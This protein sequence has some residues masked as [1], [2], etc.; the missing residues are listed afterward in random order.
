[1][2]ICQH[3]LAGWQSSRSANIPTAASLDLRHAASGLQAQM[4]TVS[5]L[6]LF[7]SKRVN[8]F[9]YACMIGHG[10]V[11]KRC[12]FAVAELVTNPRV[13]AVSPQVT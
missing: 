1:M 12:I 9:E 13:Q 6:P 4:T 3:C 7:I 5:F 11:N 2:C 8:S 10:G